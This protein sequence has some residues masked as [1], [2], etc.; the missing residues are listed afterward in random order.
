MYLK[1]T[2]VTVKNREGEYRDRFLWNKLIKG[3]V[4][5]VMLVV[6]NYRHLILRKSD[7]KSLE[8]YHVT[9]Y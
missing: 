3:G 2:S 8:L 9:K 4:M 7:I 5:K 1:K 6:T